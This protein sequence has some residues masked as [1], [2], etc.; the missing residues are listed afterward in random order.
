MAQPTHCARV[1]DL[2]AAFNLALPDSTILAGP[3]RV[4]LT[5]SVMKLTT[6]SLPT[7]LELLPRFPTLLLFTAAPPTVTLDTR[8]AQ[9]GIS[10]SCPRLMGWSVTVRAKSIRFSVTKALSLTRVL[11]R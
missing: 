6:E 5:L 8:R 1:A 9:E 2:R 7:A 3:Q 10:P 4:H 11:S